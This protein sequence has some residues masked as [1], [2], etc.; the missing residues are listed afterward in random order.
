MRFNLHHIKT[1]AFWLNP[2]T[3]IIVVFF[4][5]MALFDRSSFL[6]QYRINRT[7]NT[8]ETEIQSYHQLYEQAL[9]DKKNL[10]VNA[11]KYARENYNFSTKGEEIFIIK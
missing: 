1:Q 3:I 10:Q 11:E 5:W 6:E 8:L 9:K 2:Y 4:V 7:L